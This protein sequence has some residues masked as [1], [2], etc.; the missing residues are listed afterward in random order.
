MS[1]RD[2]AHDMR[3]VIDAACSGG[4]YKPPQLATEIVAKLRA[5]D[6]ELLDGWLQAQ[7]EHFIWQMIND[8]DRSRRTH[9][10]YAGPRGAF[11]DAAQQYSNGQAGA[12][13]DFL[14]LRFTVA[15]GSRPELAALTAADLTYVADDY[16]RREQKNALMKA[17]MR[18][19]A[20][21]VGTGTVG[22]HFTN[23]Q[24]A[25]MFDSFGS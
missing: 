3:E 16:E 23:E 14:T 21:K 17:V 11:A 22:D 12:L 15:D 9:A 5:N 8:I 19:L 13:R 20:K 10:R 4:G 6:V 2:Y 18:A 1:E 24:L 7:A 25:A